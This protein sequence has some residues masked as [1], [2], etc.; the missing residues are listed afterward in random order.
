MNEIAFF[1][2]NILLYLF[3]L[4]E[5]LKREIARKIFSTYLESKALRI[6][7]QVVQE[8][9]SAATK[10]LR[11]PAFQAADEVQALCDLEMVTVTRVEILRALD[12]GQRIQISFWDAL[13]VAA[14]ET[15]GATILFTEDLTHGQRFGPIQIVNPF[16][17]LSS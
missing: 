15:A 9:Y 10:R 2:T 13:I 5:V 4:R 6:S 1:D 12:I 17:T 16:Q 8:F 7:T 11:I 3:D 14:A